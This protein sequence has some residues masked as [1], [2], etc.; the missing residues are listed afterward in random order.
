MC[1]FTSVIVPVLRSSH[2]RAKY[3]LDIIVC[4]GPENSGLRHTRA[5]LKASDYKP[6]H[7]Q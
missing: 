7:P 2:R 1:L 4:R 6:S 5:R 3:A